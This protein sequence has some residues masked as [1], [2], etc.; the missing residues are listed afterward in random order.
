MIPLSGRG[1]YWWP[2]IE[3]PRT[4]VRGFGWWNGRRQQT[5]Q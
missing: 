2:R 4:E 3:Y 1:Y 5:I